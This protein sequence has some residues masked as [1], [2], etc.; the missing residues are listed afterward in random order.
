MWAIIRDITERKRAEEALRQSEQRMA[1]HVQQTPLGAIEWDLEF[2]VIRWNPGAERIFGYAEGEALGH[3]AAF[4][5][6]PSAR[7]H[8]DGVWKDLVAQKG[9][10][11]STNGNITKDGR[12]ILCEWYNTPLIDAEG[13]AI[14]VA[15]LVEDITERVRAEQELQRVHRELERRV[16]E[17]TAELHDANA[18]LQREVEERNLPRYRGPDRPAREVHVCIARHTGPARF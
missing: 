10:K 8:V 13:R 5:I 3:H 9:G 11:R 18:E 16:E 15:S 4:I 1:L 6:A 2:R 7:G 14:G 17:R 12:L